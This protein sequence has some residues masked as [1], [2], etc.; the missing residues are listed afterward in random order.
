M[1]AAMAALCVFAMLLARAVAARNLVYPLTVGGSVGFVATAA[2]GG[3]HRHAYGRFMITGLVACGVGDLVG[4]Y[5]FAAGAIAFL[6]AHL[7]FIAA[8][9]AQGI[10][11]RRVLCASPAAVFAA[12][13]LAAWLLP[14]VSGPEVWLVVAYLLVI[15]AM[16]VAAYGANLTAGRGLL[17]SGAVLFYL[18]DIFLARWRY[19]SP[20]GIHAFFC[21]PLYY[22]ACILLALSISSVTMANERKT[23]AYSNQL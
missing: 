17:T 23:N 16:L 18:S 10:L 22:A 8:C 9:F 2:A 12:V 6:L 5:H 15:T 13:L 14:H 1:L 20:N 3:A 19:V 4:P 21:Y 7:A 11:K